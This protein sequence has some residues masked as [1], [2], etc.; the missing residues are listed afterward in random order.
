MKVLHVKP[1]NHSPDLEK[2][3]SRLAMPSWDG[4]FFY[5]YEIDFPDGFEFGEIKKNLQTL[6][7]V[8][9]TFMMSVRR[10]EM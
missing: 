5:F 9:V 6:Y 1:S 4:T 7:K 3:K 2:W 8:P 10:D